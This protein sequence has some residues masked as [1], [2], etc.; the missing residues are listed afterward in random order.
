MTISMK[1]STTQ[2]ELLQIFISGKSQLR[3]YVNLR[4]R[5][6][7]L[8]AP[9]LDL[10]SG[11]L[12]TASYQRYIAG[13][14]GAKV[15]SLDLDRERRPSALADLNEAFP[16]KSEG[17]GTVLAFLVLEYLHDLDSVLGEV[18]RVL[19]PG[20][21]IVFALPFLDRLDTVVGESARLTE[22]GW[23][24]LLARAGFR[25]IAITAEGSGAAGAALDMIEFAVPR[26]LRGLALRLAW[27]LDSWLTRRSGGRFRNASDYPLAYF[28][29]ARK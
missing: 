11:G 22:A 9:V 17:F 8:N 23:A 25:E 6:V 4:A 18:Y 20:G 1:K 21:Q 28:I 3:A 13:Y 26:F 29:T 19:Q 5:E 24:R 16:C 12:G 15:I 27:W 10:G 14:A 7:Q 2:R